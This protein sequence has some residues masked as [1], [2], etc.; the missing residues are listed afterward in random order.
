MKQKILHLTYDYAKENLGKSTVVI[1]NLI[2]VT[3]EF[4]VTEI[5]SL[6]R[7]ASPM[8]LWPQIVK[9]DNIMEITHFG[10]PGGILLLFNSKFLSDVIIKKL[11]L[12]SYSDIDII[13]S[14]KLT[15]E[16]FIGYFIAKKLRKKLFLSLRQT[17]FFVLKY[18]PDLIK[19]ARNQLIYASKI[20]YIA[21]YMK[22]EMEKL[23]GTNF[24]N[25]YIIE[26][27]VFLPNTIDLSRFKHTRTSSSENFLTI[28]W[29][30]K[31][32]VKRKNLYKIL[33]AVKKLNIKLDIIG[34]GNYDKKIK[35][36]INKLGIENNVKLLGFV[37]N[38]R[39]S[40]YLNRAK[41][42][43]MP[44]K[45]ETFGVAYAEALSCGTPI[46]YSKNTGFDGLFDGVGVCVDPSSL[47]EIINGIEE[48]TNKNDEFRENIK[49]LNSTG[50][51]N[52]FDRMY[53]EQVYRNA[54]D[55]LS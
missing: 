28:C 42:F 45:S 12:F 25:K 5:I 6:K 11:H 37:P 22:K 17:D 24:Y 46:M 8:Y 1:N 15:F 50:A 44:S 53:A 39:I 49:K 29:L 38:E 32:V 9:N 51:F 40:E 34:H 10:L 33:L 20:F 13:H 19:T 52:I 18:R 31:D 4:T 21:P 43:L 48:L 7:V 2:T 3:S 26:K 14:H 47:D 23:F 41:G 30:K 27:M 36:W 35:L 55:G 54:V 16:G